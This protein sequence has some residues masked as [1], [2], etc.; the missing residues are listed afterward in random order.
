MGEHVNIDVANAQLVLGRLSIGGDVADT[1]QAGTYPG[2]QLTVFEGLSHIVISPCL[3]PGH[4]ILGVTAGGEH[5]NGHVRN[6]PNAAADFNAVH[7]RQ[8]QIQQH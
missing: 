7:T 1:A 2:H 5:N 4:H 6:S 8:H 3:Q